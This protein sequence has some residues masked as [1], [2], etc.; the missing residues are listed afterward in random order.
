V[1]VLLGAFYL[2]PTVFGA[3]GRLYTPDLFVT[4]NTDAVVLLLPGRLVPGVGGLLLTALVTAGAFAAFLSTTTGLVVTVAGTLAQDLLPARARRADGHR[5]WVGPGVAAALRGPG[6][7]RLRW[8]SLVAGAVPLLL[9]LRLASLPV[10]E[11]VGLAFAVA[12]SSFCPLLVLG[13]WWRR[14]TSVGAGAGVLCGGGSAAT[15]VVAHLLGWSPN[16]WLGALVDQPAAWTVPLAFTVM[17]TVSLATPHRAPTDVART[18]VQLHA[19][20]SLGLG[21][22][23]AAVPTARRG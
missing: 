17:V 14:L 15:V 9:A 18:M 16:G 13:V 22:V 1:L 2:M 4:G 6:L 10:S 3:L 11:V 19:P 23:A 21:R 12:A 7:G 20:E 5:G 8:A